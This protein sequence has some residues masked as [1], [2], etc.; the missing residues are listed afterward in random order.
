M[1]TAKEVPTSAKSGSNITSRNFTLATLR[2][3]NGL[4]VKSG[5]KKNSQKLMKLTLNYGFVFSPEVMGNYTEEELIGFIPEITDEIGLSPQQMNASFH[6]S[7]VKVEQSPIF[8]LVIEQ[9][10]HYVTTYGFEWFGVYNSNTV[11][12]PD[13]KLRIPDLK[14]GIRL[15]VINGYTMAE[16]KT[17]LMTLL[18]SGVALK[19]QTVKDAVEI[20]TGINFTT[21]DMEQVKNR[22]VKIQLYDNLN[23][24]PENPQ[25][26]LRLMI[27]KTTGKSLI[28]KSPATIKTIK[29]STKGVAKHFEQ[30]ENEYGLEKLSKIFFRFKPLFLAFKS[31]N[32]MK[33]IVNRLRKLADSYHEPMQPDLLNNITAILARGDIVKLSY[34][35]SELKKLNTF[36]KIRLAYA[37]NYRM[38]SPESIL[39]K[40]RNGK[41][42][43]T[44]FEFNVTKHAKV[45]YDTIME[46]IVADLKKNVKGKKIFL[47]DNVKYAVP[48]TEKQFTGNIP[49]GSFVSIPKDMLVGIYWENVNGQ[50]IDIDLSLLSA[51]GKFGWDRHY[52][53][54]D[55]SILFSGDMTDA[56]NGASELF[57]IRK[58]PTG[59]YMLMANFFNYGNLT[60]PFKILV[61]KELAKDFKMNYMV[62][63]NNVICIAKTEVTGESKQRMLG[64][65][66]ATED[67]CRFYFNE[68]AIGDS[69][70]AT[71]NDYTQHARNYLIHNTSNP[72][73]LNDLLV[74]AGAKIVTKKGKDVIDLSP[75]ALSKDTILSLL[76]QN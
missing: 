31:E 15:T 24:I 44:S 23:L 25:E 4:P 68:T 19:E 5:N 39:Y 66:V 56:T 59:A 64:L 32:Q 50:R 71:N 76:V 27:Y 70:T 30:Y 58:A 12:I 43:A 53:R 46:S 40:V 49:S 3:F 28:I 18:G 57:Y 63:P 67:D 35:K 61:A 38:S 10:M 2:L 41:G 47:P 21:K 11:Y 1:K 45:V 62:N 72:I 8:Q 14:D 69:V 36:R 52:R 48:A 7:W 16:I 74:K 37:L 20:A 9:L 42:Y 54:D 34:L 55:G 26:F 65:V 75:E 22:E 13:E 6:K 60:V 29:G 33:P 73:V 51:D 17:K